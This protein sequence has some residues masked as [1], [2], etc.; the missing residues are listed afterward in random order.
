MKWITENT[1]IIPVTAGEA[2]PESRK[3]AEEERGRTVVSAS[4]SS[5]AAII[6]GADGPTAIWLS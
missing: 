1:D 2:D 4:R 5:S 6:G 3:Y